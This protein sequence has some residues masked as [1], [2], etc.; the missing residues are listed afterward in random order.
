[1]S[2]DA[3]TYHFP[4]AATWL[5]TGR[6]TLFETWFFNPANT[7]SP[8]AG[9]AF[10][11]WLLAPMGND[12]IAT[13][14]QIPALVALWFVTTRLARE[15]GL[16]TF[17]ASLAATTVAVAQPFIRASVLS[18]D[19][20]FVAFLFTAAL[21]GLSKRLAGDRLG[22]WRIGVAVG[23]LLA[24]KYTALLT[25]PVLLLAFDSPMQARWSWRKWAVAFACVAAIAGPWYLRNA[26]SYGNPLFPVSVTVAG[27]TLLPGL[28]E[29]AVSPTLRSGAG[30]W[31]VF[32]QVDDALPAVVLLATILGWAAWLA[33]SRTRI[34]TDPLTRV[35]TVGPLIGTA[36][37]LWNSPYAEI[38]F[39]YPVLV[40]AFVAFAAAAHA[41]FGTRRWGIAVLAA[42]LLLAALTGLPIMHGLQ[43]LPFGIAAG[44]L[45]AAYATYAHR[46]KLDWTHAA[47][48]GTVAVALLAGS[49]YIHWMA[50]TRHSLEL[51]TAIWEQRYGKDLAQSWKFVRDLP[52][53]TRVAY[54]NTYLVYPLMGFA[55]T[56]PVQ[57]VPA[58]H[59]ISHVA[60]LPPL[61]RVSGDE[62]IRRVTQATNTDPDEQEWLERL[63]ASQSKYLYVEKRHDAPAAPELDLADK[64]P[65]HFRV[66]FDNPAARVYEIR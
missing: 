22:P 7:Y 20:L 36:L 2:Q 26:L 23:L 13:Y 44:L 8:L 29:T 25:L 31:R 32:T 9:S 61:G 15:V 46:Y 53:Q 27:I 64:H 51:S 30:I 54:A 49:V 42:L 41:L 19:D 63:A 3:L 34:L 17:W 55:P 4:A 21:A 28:F 24:T 43:L 16:P 60:D 35:T 40:L 11:A 39:L 57:Y 10:I 65:D 62:M 45:T 58:R 56:R 50:Y 52:Q 38:R 33:A 18:K 66:L 12:T 14:V 59:G 48:A 5:Q 37:F 47:L 6:I 1:M